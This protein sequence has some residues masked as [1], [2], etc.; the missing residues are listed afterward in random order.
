MK[1]VTPTI[2]RMHKLRRSFLFAKCAPGRF[3]ANALGAAKYRE[4]NGETETAATDGRDILVAPAYAAGQSDASMLWTM[5]HEGCHIIG[6]HFGRGHG[7]D[8]R[9]WNIACDLAVNTAVEKMA[10][11]ADGRRWME[12]PEGVLMP[13]EGNFA[14]LKPGLSAETYYDLLQKKGDKGGKSAGPGDILPCKSGD[15][16]RKAKEHAQRVNV[17]AAMASRGDG[18]GDVREIVKSATLPRTADYLREFCKGVARTLVSW[19]HPNRRFVGE[20]VILPGRSPRA[21]LGKL[22]LAIDTSGSI[23]REM[24]ALFCGW[25][26]AAI[27]PYPD[28]ELSVVLHHS[29]VYA[30]CEWKPK[31]GKALADVIPPAQSGGTSHRGV[32]QK[33]AS[34]P[35]ITAI[36][37]LTDLY[38]EFPPVAPNVPVLWVSAGLDKA[39]FGRV[40]PLR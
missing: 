16:A 21:V 10:V 40:A 27:E 37:C 31:S 2:E 23:D 28:A 15:E 39:P 4:A 1:K 7:R 30:S 29:D 26:Q 17:N 6:Q 25:I 9:L 11:T 8:N 24:L 22:G 3:L 34:D 33:F 20:D 36:V 13:G 14:D 18:G 32:F 5:A 35:K 19:S 38:T 12:K